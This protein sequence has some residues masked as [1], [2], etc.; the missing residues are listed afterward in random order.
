MKHI[1][2]VVMVAMLFIG[3]T[4]KE[5]KPKYCEG[6]EIAA[7]VVA[8]IFMLSM[9]CNLKA[10]QTMILDS[11]SQGECVDSQ[12][13][14]RDITPVVMMLC[15]TVIASVKSIGISK[16]VGEAG[17]NQDIVKELFDMASSDEMCAFIIT[18]SAI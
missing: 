4:K 12:V 6:A 7:Q 11:V 2:F 5:G 1:L 9:G 14:N 10:T 13:K 18:K 3:C 15:K 8:P 17:C 16:L